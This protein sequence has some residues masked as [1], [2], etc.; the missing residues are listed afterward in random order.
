MK[1]IKWFKMSWKESPWQF[2]FIAITSAMIWV[3]TFIVA[4]INNK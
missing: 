2:K 3:I 4:I 1:F